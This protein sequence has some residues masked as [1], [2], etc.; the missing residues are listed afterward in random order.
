MVARVWFS[1]LDEHALLGL[2]RLVQALG[3]APAL[4]DAAGE[5]VDDL[6]LAVG[7]HVVLVAVEEVLGLEGLL[8]VVG[9]AGPLGSA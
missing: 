3:A 8:Q 1:S 7:D 2:D 4:H 9:R 5:L 6:H